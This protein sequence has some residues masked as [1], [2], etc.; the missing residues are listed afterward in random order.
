MATFLR[1]KGAVSRLRAQ[2]SEADI[3]HAPLRVTSPA[4]GGG[5]HTSGRKVVRGDADEEWNDG[6]MSASSSAIA[7]LAPHKTKLMAG[8]VLGLAGVLLL[9][10]LH[11]PAAT[12]PLAQVDVNAASG[13]APVAG[14]ESTP[15]QAQ[16]SGAVGTVTDPATA[17]PASALNPAPA[18]S[19]AF[20]QSGTTNDDFGSDG[21]E[22]APPTHAKPRGVEPFGNGPVSHG[23]VLHVKMDGAIEKIEG[24][25]T[26]NGFTVVIPGRKSIDAA[27]PLAQRDERIASIKMTNEADSAELN[28]AFRDGVPNYQVRA[29]GST[30]EIA[31]APVGTLAEAKHAA[32][33]RR[34]N[35]STHHKHGKR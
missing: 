25:A 32:K 8:G 23:N 7:A 1:A 2:K 33:E 35:G 29:H 19:P 27:G 22:T 24:A 9:V 10:A 26:P 3:A 21:T 31:L 15:G 11:K 28:V 17:A 5:L 34:H 20:A 18:P 16:T 13:S 12:A 4:P 6:P 30:L 14:A